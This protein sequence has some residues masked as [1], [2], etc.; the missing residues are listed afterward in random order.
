MHI[1]LCKNNASKC[2]PITKSTTDLITGNSI[3]NKLK[4]PLVSTIMTVI[5][6]LWQKRVNQLRDV[7][8]RKS[9]H[10]E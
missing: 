9:C 2:S 6:L 7:T 5:I 3:N 8:K 1:T 4:I 10:Y